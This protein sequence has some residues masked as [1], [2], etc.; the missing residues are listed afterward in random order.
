MNKH[1]FQ[2]EWA[3]IFS[4]VQA[5]MTA[6]RREHP[7]A[8]M[9]AIELETQ[10]V[11]SRLQARLV[12]DVAQHSDAAF[13]AD[14]PPLERPLCPVCAVPVQPRGAKER[15]LR[16]YGNQEIGL[17]REHATCPH[18][19]RAFFPSGPRIGPPAR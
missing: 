9:V 19:E 2:P 16:G 4:E 17:A 13:F 11:L 12:T 15:Q 8:T 3:D 7:K 10:R 18:C 1:E 14:R 6:W 5:A